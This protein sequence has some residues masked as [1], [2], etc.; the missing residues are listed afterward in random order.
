FHGT[1]AA[2]EHAINP[3]S[4]RKLHVGRAPQPQDPFLEQV[5]FDVPSTQL[6]ITPQHTVM[7]WLQLL[8]KP[9]FFQQGPKL[10]RAPYVLN[11]PHLL[12][13]P[14]CAVAAIIPTEVRQHTR[15]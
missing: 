4:E 14:Q 11:A 5:R 6:P 9:R 13:Q 8:N 2:P 15:T 7:H 3:P 10:A 1:A 12:A